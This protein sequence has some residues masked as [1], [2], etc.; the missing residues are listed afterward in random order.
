MA[1]AHLPDWPDDITPHVLR[2]FCASQLYL[3]GM[4]L[5]AIQEVLGHAWI[6]TTMRYVHVP[7][8]HVED[9]WLAGQA[10]AVTRL[11]GLRR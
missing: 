5:L 3:A 6:A 11:E 1:T 8:T 4:D 7:S 9:A 10:R 2:H